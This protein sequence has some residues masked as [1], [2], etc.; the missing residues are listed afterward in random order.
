MFLVEKSE[1]EPFDRIAGIEW[2]AVEFDR[3]LQGRKRSLLIDYHNVGHMLCMYARPHRRID[4]L[5][6]R[7]LRD[8]L[9]R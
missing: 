6:L 2:N 7:S 3:S 9:S 8:L 4:Q 5:P 1:V